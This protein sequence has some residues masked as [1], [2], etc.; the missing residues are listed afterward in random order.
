MDVQDKPITAAQET[1]KNKVDHP[2][3]ER[4]SVTMTQGRGIPAE[5]SP[6]R[7]R[8]SFQSPSKPH[9]GKIEA[10]ENESGRIVRFFDCS[11]CSFKG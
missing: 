4:E 7:A 10:R 3:Q 1:T 5:Y 11:D 6:L 9:A 8:L 2:A